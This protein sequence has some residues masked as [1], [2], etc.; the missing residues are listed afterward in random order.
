MEVTAASEPDGLGVV[1]TVQL[2]RDTSKALW[3]VVKAG[4]DQRIER[5]ENRGGYVYL[6]F[7]PDSPRA[8][9]RASF[10]LAGYGS[11]EETTDSSGD[12]SGS[13]GSS[14]GGTEG[15][16]D[17]AGTVEPDGDGDAAGE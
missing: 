2:D 12:A 15:D 7:V 3:P 16:D 8:D 4:R 13:E 6:T 11:N 14:S 9:S 1:R 5:A 10:D 17:E